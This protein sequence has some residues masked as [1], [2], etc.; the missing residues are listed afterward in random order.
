MGVIILYRCFRACSHSL[1]E[2]WA[3]DHNSKLTGLDAV[4]NVAWLRLLLARIVQFRPGRVDFRENLMLEVQNKQS[5]TSNEGC[6]PF[7]RLGEGLTT[8]HRKRRARYEM[9]HRAL[10]LAGYCE[11][12]NELSDFIIGVELRDSL[13]EY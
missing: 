2:I 3:C 11:Y 6:L 1:D 10:E 12:S 7:W 4:P 5:L 8:P 9:L 13:S